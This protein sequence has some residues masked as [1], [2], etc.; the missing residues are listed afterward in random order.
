MRHVEE[1]RQYLYDVDQKIDFINSLDH[2]S[3]ERI[4]MLLPIYDR[5]NMKKVCT[6][7]KEVCKLAWYDIQKYK[8][9]HTIG[10]AYNDQ[11]LTQSYVENLMS[12][13]GIHLRELIL[14][15][16]CTSSIMPIIGEH[17]K[18]L[19]SLE[20]VFNNNDE[21]HDI[22]DSAN[23]TD[24]SYYDDDDDINDDE[25]VPHLTVFDDLSKLEHLEFLNVSGIHKFTDS[26]I[27]AV[28][29]KCKSLKNLNISRCKY[30]TE[31]GLNAITSLE[32]LQNLNVSNIKSVKNSFI[33]KLKSLTSFEAN[34]CKKITDSGIIQFIKN[35]PNLEHLHLF[36]TNMTINTIIG[37]DRETKYQNM[38]GWTKKIIS[39]DRHLSST[40]IIN[41]YQT[42]QFDEIGNIIWHNEP[43]MYNLE[44]E[45]KHC[46]KANILGIWNNYSLAE[47]KA[48]PIGS[49][50]W[51]IHYF[52]IPT[53][54]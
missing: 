38:V 15:K 5:I 27:I 29:N 14:S 41:M 42:I 35:C 9:S 12:I 43:N 17:C 53:K 45:I 30:I 50:F 4:F 24:E 2:Y 20:F 13:F 8:C 36:R 28:A 3:L 10:R 23:D 46:N 21:D 11:L 25:P 1:E 32:L 16:I 22:Y 48:Q 44:I 49:G 37:A 47:K 39:E 51:E 31:A 19:T 33:I 34:K 6:R 52:Q 54:K 26:S 40:D 18:N 7:W